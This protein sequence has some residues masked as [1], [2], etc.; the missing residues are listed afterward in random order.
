[1]ARLWAKKR[2]QRR[3]PKGVAGLTRMSFQRRPILSLSR[4][5]LFYIPLLALLLKT[6]G[7]D[8]VF[9]AM[10]VADIL[11]VLASAVFMFFELKRLRGQQR[12]G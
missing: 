1:M 10:P 2:A 11:A 4:Q 7:L 6:L 3:T 9:F 8:G 12:D 5:S